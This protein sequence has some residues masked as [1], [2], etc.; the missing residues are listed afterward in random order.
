LA[1][2]LAFPT[3]FADLVPHDVTPHGTE[4]QEVMAAVEQAVRAG[5]ELDAAVRP[6]LAELTRITGMEAAYLTGIAPHL[7]THE[8]LAS[9][10]RDGLDVP[11]GEP[12]PWVDTLCHR[13]LTVGPR[14]SNDVA[15]DYPGNEVATELGIHS[16]AMVPVATT[17][18]GLV[19][20][21][22]AVSR[23]P[24]TVDAGTVRL[25]EVFSRL[26][27]EAFERR[28]AP[29]LEDV[30]V[31]VVD[32][33]PLVQRLVRRVLTTGPG[34]DVVAEATTGAEAVDVCRSHRPDVV[35]LDLNIGGTDGLTVLPSVLGVCPEA[36]VVVLSAQAHARRAEALDAGAHAVVD[37]RDGIEH[38]RAVVAAVL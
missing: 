13:A 36:K 9:Y 38:L 20:T 10:G 8:V 28:E 22:C 37:K 27:A 23:S 16:Y 19:G 31:V 29:H 7:G 6:L 25:M 17:E 14:R 15:R 33:S 5:G 18:G 12:T 11:E 24:C 32:D 4:L 26:L 35:V 2:L 30:R 3:P 34:I 1:E 21:L